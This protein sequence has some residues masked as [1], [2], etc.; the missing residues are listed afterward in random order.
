MSSLPI[1]VGGFAAQKD[2]PSGAVR[3]VNGARLEWIYLPS[4]RTYISTRCTF[5][6]LRIRY[7]HSIGPSTNL[8]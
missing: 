7:W 4:G 8:R 1:A 2:Q 6:A 5:N 3:S